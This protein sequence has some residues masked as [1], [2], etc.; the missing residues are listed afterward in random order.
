M[1]SHSK[2][3]DF[4]RRT[5]PFNELDEIAVFRDNDI[6]TGNSRC[7]EDHVIVRLEHSELAGGMGFDTKRAGK[8]PAK[9]GDKWASSQSFTQ[10]IRG[11]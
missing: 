4:G 2:P 1:Y 6:N 8:P 11:D 5:Q 10:P 3:D 9:L 7:F